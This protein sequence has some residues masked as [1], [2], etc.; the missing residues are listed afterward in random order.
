MKKN[1]YLNNYFK[2]IVCDVDDTISTAIT[3]DW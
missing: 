2:T 3:H 1:P